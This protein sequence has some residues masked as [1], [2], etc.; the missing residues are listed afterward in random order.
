MDTMELV[1]EAYT[2]L[3]DGRMHKVSLTSEAGV[4]VTAYWAGTV[5]RIDI[6]GER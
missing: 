6:Q 5:L 1:Q 2:K 4:K 3:M